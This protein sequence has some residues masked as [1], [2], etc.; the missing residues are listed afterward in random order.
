M[1]SKKLSTFS[2]TPKRMGKSNALQAEI[3]SLIVNWLPTEADCIWVD[4]SPEF[5]EEGEEGQQ[6][7]K[8]E[9]TL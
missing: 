3:K 1:D 4:D 7:T 5:H 9:G 2:L 8:G 6:N